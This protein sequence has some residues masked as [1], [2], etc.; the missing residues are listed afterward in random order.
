MKKIGNRNREMK[1]L[2]SIVLLFV[3]P[4]VMA[5]S[6]PNTFTTGTPALASEVNEN[7]ANLDGRVN[8]NASNLASVN[9]V[10]QQIPASIKFHAISQAQEGVASAACPADTLPISASCYCEGDGSSRNFGYMFGCFNTADG[11]AAGCYVEPDLFDPALPDPLANVVAVCISAT[12]VNGDP[13]LIDPWSAAA[14]SGA[15][16]SLKPSRDTTTEL[17]VIDLQN[18]V[19]NQRSAIAAKSN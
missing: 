14:T 9:A 4:A 10:L 16:G 6:V 13:G 18:A 17:A 15:G 8:T 12:L 2:A 19:T 7:F 5:Q 3:G 1:F 11:A